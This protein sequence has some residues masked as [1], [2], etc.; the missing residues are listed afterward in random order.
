MIR[1]HIA[2]EEDRVLSE[3]KRTG[4]NAKIAVL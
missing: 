2:P 3:S 4:R 1:S